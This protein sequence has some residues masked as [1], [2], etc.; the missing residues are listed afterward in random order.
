MNIYFAVSLIITA[1]GLGFK[2]GF[3]FGKTRDTQKHT[4][5]CIIKRQADGNSAV[6]VFKQGKKIRWYDGLI[7]LWVL[8]RIWIR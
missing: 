3:E 6:T 1:F 2:F 8:L 4:D 7:G 5:G